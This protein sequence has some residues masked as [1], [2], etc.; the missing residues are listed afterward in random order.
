MADAL[1]PT[2]MPTILP[3]S[4]PTSSSEATPAQCF[5]WTGGRA[6]VA[7][8]SPFA[9][10]D[11]DGQRVEAAQANNVYVFPGVGLGAIV[12]EAPVVTDQMFLAAA[13]TLAGCVSEDRLRAG[14]LFPPISELRSVARAIALAV[15]GPGFESQID[16]AMWQPAYVPYLAERSVE[17]RQR[18]TD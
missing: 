14:F 1:G 17:R 6:L 5:A 4:N 7:T 9:P 15:A 12:S 10:A 16:A 18:T 8:G 11:V 13:R 2:E 3:L